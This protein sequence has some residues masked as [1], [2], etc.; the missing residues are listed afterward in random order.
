MAAAVNTSVR[1]R[2]TVKR[3]E[4]THGN[5][6]VDCP[7]PSKML[8]RC[9][10]RSGEEFTRLRYS[11]VTCDPDEFA[12]SHYTLRPVLYGRQTELFVVVTMY[13]EDDTLFCRTINGVMRNIQHL[14][15]RS[16]SSTWGETG[17]QKVVVCIVADGRQ[18]VHPRVLSVLA[19]MGVYQDGIAKN[20]VNGREVKAH[21]FEYTT[22][23][24]VSSGMKVLG[25]DK[26]V[27]PCQMLFCLKE[28]N[29]KKI[30]SHRWF[31]NAFAP[32]LNPNVCVLLD[33]G[34]RPGDT[35]IYQLWKA[36][37]LDPLVGG[38]CGEVG[39]MKGLAWWH[40]LNPLVAAQH[41]E[42]KLSNILDKP[43][44]STL[45]Y[46]MVLPG[47]FSAYRY[48]AV[49]DDLSGH[50][51]LASY[52]KGEPGYQPLRH[53]GQKAAEQRRKTAGVFEANMYLAEDRV[54]CFEVV[55]KRNERWLLRY[56]RSAYGETDVPQSLAEFIAQRRRWLNGSFFAAVYALVH[57]YRI[58]QSRHSLVRNLV[59]LLQFIYT[60]YNV[61]FAWFGMA[62]FYLTYHF[63]ARTMA[64][65]NI[66][67][68]PGNYG[69]LVV[70]ILDYLYLAL[71]L[72][73]F[74]CSLG[75]R[76]QGSKLLY[77]GAMICFSLFMAYMI[78]GA[79][80]LS[81]RGVHRALRQMAKEQQHVT[82][83]SVLF[84]NSTTRDLIIAVGSTYGVYFLASLL[85][86]QPW[87]MITS[88]VQYT[89]MV[90]TYINVLNVYAFC[91]THDVSWG[92]KSQGAQKMDLGVAVPMPHNKGGSQTVQLVLPGIDHDLN[93][94]YEEAL[95]VIK[96]PVTHEHHCRD[97]KT[98]QEDYY[99]MIRTWLVLFWIMT[100]AVLA[101][102]IVSTEINGLLDPG[103][104]DNMDAANPAKGFYLANWYFSFILWSV[105]G[106]VMF[107]FIGSMIYLVRATFWR[108]R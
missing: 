32:V 82:V 14:C 37:D 8:E 61:V 44:E 39:V 17:W 28:K 95:T 15:S 73:M 57:W 99:R 72:S 9:V 85:Y 10:Y 101:L 11:A 83:V 54:L 20:Q 5:L 59:F 97:A 70:R 3:V 31:F 25:P 6:V 50:G 93:S 104:D 33:V 86:L 88:F 94:A 22:Q 27:I 19:A 23:L 29:G 46:I 24:S 75:N 16:R 7:V 63:I 81:I 89:L 47:A 92:T 71:M 60:L 77:M 87:H 100:N 2:R 51:P 26:G 48:A 34:T 64:N 49:R 107:R 102:V 62:N 108:G 41:F 53:P 35:S 98:R 21:L 4:L 96:T 30:N 90:P 67:P 13:N 66:D 45:G 38:A 58:W 80:F 76:P 36:F 56:V 84:G 18:N 69:Q 105:A 12:R 1:R 68:I 40:L 79:V 42:Y 103:D 52:F 74:I 91:N 78:G 106:L 55:A 65:P 43:L